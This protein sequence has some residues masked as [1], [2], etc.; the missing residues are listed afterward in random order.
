SAEL[1]PLQASRHRELDD[2]DRRPRRRGDSDSHHH[3]RHQ[4]RPDDAVDQRD[5]DR[6]QRDHRDRDARRREH[7]RH[8]Q[9]HDEDQP[10]RRERSRSRSADRFDTRRERGGGGGGGRGRGRR[11]HRQ[12]QQRFE[13]GRPDQQRVKSETGEEPDEKK[14]PPPP[15]QMANMGLSGKLAEDTNMYKGVLIKYSEPANARMPKKRW[16]LYP[17]KGEEAM[18]PLYVHRQSGY[19]IGRDR[20]VADI[21]LDHPSI[22]K[23]HAALQY[24]LV[25]LEQ[26]DGSKSRLV[27]PYIIDLESANGTYL[28]GERVEA[29]RYIELKERDVLKFGYSSREYVVLSENAG[30]GE[31]RAAAAGGD[32]R[33]PPSDSD[34]S[35]IEPM[36]AAAASRHRQR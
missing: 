3:R 10:R 18:K 29:R 28:N 19:L 1:D 14:P 20:K 34:D 21:P 30:E 26:P 12:Q 35:D 23:Q 6:V 2:T 9:Q 16:R 24:R 15:K 11:E 32:D 8:S 31:D 17:F 36:A 13:W 25:E 33:V 7:H 22:S 4:H 27:K 5:A